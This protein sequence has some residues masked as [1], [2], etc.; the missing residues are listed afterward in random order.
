MAR[1]ERGVVRGAGTTGVAVRETG[2]RASP[3]TPS[4]QRLVLSAVRV[5]AAAPDGIH[6]S[7][8]LYLFPFSSLIPSPPIDFQGSGSA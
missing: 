5:S 7:A 8:H 3:V 2:T 6:L 4:T 1:H